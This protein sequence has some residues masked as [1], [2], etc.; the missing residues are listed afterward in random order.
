MHSLASALLRL[1]I[2]LRHN[3]RVLSAPR[4]TAPPGFALL[5]AAF[6]I[7]L[8]PAS[9][10]GARTWTV[11]VQ[12]TGDAATIEAAIQRSA[13]GDTV[14]VEPG[15]YFE[16]FSFLGK[17]IVVRSLMGPASTILDGS[18]EDSS[19]VT[20]NGG[21]TNAAILEG[22]TL[23]GGKGTPSGGPQT[24]GGAIFV[25]D[26]SPL[27]QYNVIQGNAA[28]WGGG[29]VAGDIRDTLPTTPRLILRG[30]TI[31]S[32]SATNGGGGLMLY[33]GISLIEGNI[34][35]AN[36]TEIGDGGGIKAHINE[37]S[38]TISGN[39]FL[40]NEARDKGGGIDVYSSRVFGAGPYDIAD[41]LF[42]RN[43]ALGADV[44]GDRGAGGAMCLSEVH[45]SV[46]SNTIYSNVGIGKSPCGAGGVKFL[47]TE[48]DLRFSMNIVVMN[49][50]CGIACWEGG[51]ASFGPNLFW[52]NDT[53]DLGSLARTC[54][55]A[56]ETAIIADPLFCDPEGNDFRLSS[57]TPAIFDGTFLGAFPGTGC[58]TDVMVLPITWGS[59]KRWA[60]DARRE[61]V[62]GN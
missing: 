37:G 55:G 34:F 44:G 38:V 6:A 56:S 23:T 48:L 53:D 1:R 40:D 60:S 13:D 62:I 45:G 54:P 7:P 46:V 10:V 3:R 47:R 32:N 5:L 33:S 14:L 59:L 18:R 9:D 21:E 27:I 50:G 25:R 19:M 15:R 17:D 35:Q 31:L 2:A 29:I 11:N 58:V 16:D 61:G 36:R 51:V 49:S 8:L 42:V 43:I 4:E 57:G 52:S 20:F 12:G 39:T 41:N 24:E 28:W 26:A 22:F 30:N